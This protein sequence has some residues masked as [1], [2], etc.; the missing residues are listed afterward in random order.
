MIKDKEK[1]ILSLRDVITK[2]EDI[3]LAYL[4]GS[5]AEDRATQ[6]SDLD[7]AILTRS[8][9]TIPF[10]TA[11]LSKTLEIPEDKISILDIEKASSVIKLRILSK[12]IKLLDKG[13][14]EEKLRREIEHEVVEL[15]EDEKAGFKTWLKGNPIDESVLKRI[16]S[17]LSEDIEDLREI[18]SKNLEEIKHDKYLR[19]AFERT[20]ETLIE[21]VIDLLRHIISG[22]NLGIAE[23]YK[24][25][26]EICKVKGVIS[27]RIAE[28]LLE[29]IP[30]RHILVHRDRQ[31]NYQDLWINA[32]KA[33]EILPI[34][35]NEVKSY[36][37]KELNKKVIFVI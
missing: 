37:K 26:I 32:R 28:S 13:N 35:L 30:I 20:L 10:L 16:F 2:F 23:Y 21:G 4:F 36:L 34:L 31:V 33:V 3:Q 27:E 12:G 24:D 8:R 7:I 22:L 17:Q 5:Y 29:F 6:L 15:I 18:L 9:K 25:Y 1:L 19:K 11:K 14:Y